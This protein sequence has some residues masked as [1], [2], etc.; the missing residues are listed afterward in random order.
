MVIF[1]LPFA[2]EGVPGNSA[3]SW[4]SVNY[5]PIVT[6]G[7]MVAVT[8]WYMVSAKKTFKGPVTTID[9]LDTEVALPDIS[10][11]P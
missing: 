2:P 8:I 11:A 6:I 1:C 10:Q 7:T 5:A 4:S 9:Q 3:F